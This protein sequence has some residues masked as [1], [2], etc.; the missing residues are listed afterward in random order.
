MKAA[1]AAAQFFTNY[2]SLVLKDAKAIA[3]AGSVV[4][5][6]IGAILANFFPSAGGPPTNPCTYAADWAEC[7][8]GQIGPLVANFVGIEIEGVFDDL[9]QARMKGYQALLWEINV[10]TSKD[11]PDFPNMSEDV[12][13]RMFDNLNTLND[14]MLEGAPLFLQRK[15]ENAMSGLY[16]SMFSSL[17]ISTM[18]SLFG[19]WKYRTPGERYAYQ[20]LILC[21][22]RRVLDR[23]LKTRNRRL[24]LVSRKVMGAS[25]SSCR[26]CS[27]GDPSGRYAMLIRGRAVE[28]RCST[29]TSPRDAH[30]MRSA[31]R[32]SSAGR[33]FT[34]APSTAGDAAKVKQRMLTIATKTMCRS[35]A[36][37]CGSNG[38]R[39][40]PPGSSW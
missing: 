31:G 21:Y 9:W 36:T 16:L 17:H 3:L 2:M 37:S 40:S 11:S 19:T 4:F 5:A 1:K 25:S 30:G 6:S 13:E 10:T 8:W 22:A 15:H 29:G 18:T 26:P 7:V 12:R 20:Q 38:W 34:N 39:P 28:R 32:R 14:D 24:F 23:A 33:L 27:H 35:R